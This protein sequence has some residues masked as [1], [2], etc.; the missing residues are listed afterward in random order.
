MTKI[1][2]LSD[3]HD[4]LEAVKKVLKYIK[5][6]DPSFIIHSGDIISPFSL[7]MFSST[8]KK[9]YFVYG[10]NDGEKILLSKL[11]E[12]LGFTIEEQPL[13][14]DH[15]KYRIVVL[16]GVNGKDKTKRL[17]RALAKS[18]EFDLVIYGHTHEAEV[19][20]INGTLIVNPGELSG[21]LSGKSTFAIVD[22]DKK[23]VKIKEL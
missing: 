1:V 15:E 22:L 18:G 7:K 9:T 12:Q 11:A 19:L 10:N 2:V 3:T 14:I 4:N 13:F 6:I 16:H 17:V 20:N 23:E 8:G 21:Y 5:E